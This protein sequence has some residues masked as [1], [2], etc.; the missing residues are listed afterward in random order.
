MH[1]DGMTWNLETAISGAS[2]RLATILMTALVT[3]SACYRLPSEDGD[4]GR[5]IEGPM[6]TVV[7]GGLA[8]STALNLLVPPTSWCRV[9][10]RRASPSVECRGCGNLRECVCQSRGRA[11]RERA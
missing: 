2:E 5:E 9:A 8:T 3:G 7:L 10:V 4:P 11:L 6:A 1:V